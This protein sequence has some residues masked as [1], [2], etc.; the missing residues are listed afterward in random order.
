MLPRKANENLEVRLHAGVVRSLPDQLHIAEGVGDSAGLLV[1]AGR[2]KHHIGDG[3]GLGE[4]N[5]LD[6]DEGVLRVTSGSMPWL[7]T[8][9]APTTSS[10]PS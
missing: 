2:G 10:A 5:V 6:D 9:F 3:S 1:K 4:E 7:A 8:G